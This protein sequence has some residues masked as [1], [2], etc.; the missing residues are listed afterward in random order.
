[1][2]RRFDAQKIF[3]AL[4]YGALLTL[5]MPVAEAGVLSAEPLTFFNAVPTPEQKAQAR[6]ERFVQTAWNVGLGLGFPVATIAQFENRIRSLGQWSMEHELPMPSGFSLSAD[7]DAGFVIGAKAG[8]E[9]VFLVPE[10]GPVEMGLFTGLDAKF[11]AEAML[12]AGAGVS[13]IFNL[14][15]MEEIAGPI[16]GVNSELE[17]V[18][19]V[20]ASIMIDVE[21]DEIIKMKEVFRAFSSVGKRE[22]LAQLRAVLT[23]KRVIAIGAQIEFGVGVDVSAMVGWRKQIAAVSLPVS[24]VETQARIAQFKAHVRERFMRKKRQARNKNAV[25]VEAQAV[26][27]STPAEVI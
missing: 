15:K 6:I 27:Q 11:G 17:M 16:I 25:S 24:P 13:L 5:G 1:M 3:Q 10:E 22:A 12:G 7:I 14:E 8:T 18:E 9:L 20:G 4:S 2:S 21:S 19:G 23:Q 26:T